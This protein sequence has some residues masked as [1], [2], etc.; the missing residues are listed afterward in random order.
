MQLKIV[1]VKKLA[2]IFA[3]SRTFSL[4]TYYFYFQG[5]S[6]NMLFERINASGVGKIFSY[7]I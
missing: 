5:T 6:E 2:S 3:P 7:I 4:Y 1:K